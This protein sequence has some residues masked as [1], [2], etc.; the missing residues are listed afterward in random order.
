MTNQDPQRILTVYK[1]E[2]RRQ[3]PGWSVDDLTLLKLIKDT[4]T[5][6]WQNRNPYKHIIRLKDWEREL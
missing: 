3:I 4:T 6:L 2:R 5:R 1:N